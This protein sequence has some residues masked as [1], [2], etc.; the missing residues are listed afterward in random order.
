MKH[1]FVAPAESDVEHRAAAASPALVALVEAEQIRLIVAQ[2]RPVSLTHFLLDLFVSVLGWR[3]GIG[4]AAWIWLG[5][6]TV[7]QVGRAVYLVR[8]HDA[9]RID[10]R[11]LLGRQAWLLVAIGT[12]FA[13][14]MVMVFARPSTQA[15]LVLTMLLTGNAAGAVVTVAGH[16]RTF[17]MWAA[18]YGGTLIMC[19]LS[20]GTIEG[21]I[22]AG[23][24]A[25]LFVALSLY[26]RDQGR[27]L[28]RLVT[29]TE[30]LRRERDKQVQW[31]EALRH[32]RDRA[33]RA[34]EAKT[35]FFASASHDLRQPL[36]ALSYH[37][38]TV[39]A[40]AAN[41]GDETL[42]QVGS[43][44]GRAL[45]E[46]R[47]LLDSLLEVSKLDAGVIEVQRSAVDIGALLNEVGD[48]FMAEAEERGLQLRVRVTAGRPL[49]A[50]TDP[51][52]LRRILQN[53]VGNALKFTPEGTVWLQARPGGTPET[54]ELRVVDTGIGIPA[55]AQERV[56]E[57][58]CQVGNPARNRSRGLGLG[59]SIV[60]RL[61]TLLG[62]RVELSSAP[63]K[64]STFQFTLPTI[65]DFARGARAGDGTTSRAILPP[66]NGRRRI[67]V[68]DD[69]A[70]IR[71]SLTTM[72]KAYG[73]EVAA[74][75]SGSEA[76]ARVKDG[77]HP[78][79]LI[80]DFRLRA[81]ESGLAV[82]AELR[83][84]GSDAPAWL[85][86]GDTEP[87]RIAE[88]RAAGVPV[89][90]KPVDGLQLATLLREAFDR[91]P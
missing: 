47:A 1:E 56:F 61:A 33:E 31:A 35:R 43:G 84:A 54:V 32:E 68:L 25:A 23:L 85:I 66:T 11:K 74:E 37:A 57:E 16:L 21:A 46:S 50:D 39:Q 40:L 12:V 80:I 55:E 81:G 30:D 69:E 75:A 13:S 10:A 59:L 52:L 73:W 82:L 22:F 38:A 89:I 67:L 71:E 41:S 2:A 78:D 62:T 86:T 64:G 42:T 58:F 72:L 51:S 24:I 26:V 17:L 8:Q 7:V 91:E 90:Y 83:A 6:M 60:R 14:M 27:T 5:V 49:I 29:L 9:G 53:L 76:L 15:Q 77:F 79:A 44:I 28:L 34:S 18:V 3:A 19:W 70:D 65:A 20:Q 48:A 88:A 36:T 87:H 63:G 45:A 4:H